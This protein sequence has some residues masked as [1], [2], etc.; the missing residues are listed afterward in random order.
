MKKVERKASIP[1]SPIARA[2]CGLL[3]LT[4]FLCHSQ[5]LHG[6]EID[7]L[8]VA[9]NGKVI[10]E[11]DLELTRKLASI[12]NYD[13]NDKPETRD[14]EISRLVD[15]ELMRQEL[16]NFSVVQDDEAKVEARLSSLRQAYADK[17]GLSSLLKQ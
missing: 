12:I 13:R 1:G 8:I 6:D 3:I 15:L 4:L 16:K 10:T 7:R 2:F 17:G 11:W 9:V 5:L 14:A